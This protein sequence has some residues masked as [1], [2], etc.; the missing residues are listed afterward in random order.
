MKTK[1]QHTPVLGSAL[2]R[3]RKCLRP[4]Q[5]R[6]GIEIRCSLRISFSGLLTIA[7]SRRTWI[8]LIAAAAL[9]L[10]GDRLLLADS[11]R[12]LGSSGDATAYPSA[13][14]RLTKFLRP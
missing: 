3:P 1:Q 6:Q 12:T 5:Q 8:W 10:S 9:L 4:L 11:P 2:T 13:T 7:I 14:K